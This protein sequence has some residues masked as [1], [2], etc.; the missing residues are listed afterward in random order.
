MLPISIALHDHFVAPLDRRS[1]GSANCYTNARVA[2]QA[3]H[4]CP[5]SSC[6][7][8]RVVSRTIIDHENTEAS[9]RN[10]FDDLGYRILFVV[11][12]HHDE[13]VRG[14]GCIHRNIVSWLLLIA[15]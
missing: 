15:R 4:F 13:H 10:L 14:R 12:R 2:V 1:K 6:P 11:C 8:P 9:Y 7:R 5:S 3:Y